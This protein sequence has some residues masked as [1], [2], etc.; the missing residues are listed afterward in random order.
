MQLL[1]IEKLL[2][3]YFT[4]FEVLKVEP[5]A[6]GVQNT[7]HRV[8]ILVS[9]ERKKLIINQYGRTDY[10]DMNLRV[11][12]WQDL[13]RQLQLTHPVIFAPLNNQAAEAISKLADKH[14]LLFDCAQGRSLQAIP[15]KL[16]LTQVGQFIASFHTSSA[17]QPEL[18]WPSQLPDALELQP[19]YFSFALSTEDVSYCQE[20]VD[21]LNQSSWQSLPRGICHADIFIDNVFF[22][23][24]KMSAVL[25][26]FDAMHSVFL[27]DLSIAILDWVLWDGYFESNT[28]DTW[29]SDNIQAGIDELIQ[30]YESIRPLEPNESMLLP[31]VTAWTAVLFI[32]FRARRVYE[33]PESERDTLWHRSPTLMMRKLKALMENQG[34]FFAMLS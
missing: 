1:T 5:I 14:C 29:Q 30:A 18:G 34:D 9:E 15:E 27:L 22:D 33:L 4:N 3:Q 19:S 2:S 24:G 10:Q 6:A 11:Q 20:I 32:C 31:Q 17:Q 21:K 7:N 12:F 25:D 8:E 23:Q 28:E 13:Q 16:H 26:W